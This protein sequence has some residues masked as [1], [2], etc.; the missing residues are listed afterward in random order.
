LGNREACIRVVQESDGSVK[1]FEIKSSDATANPYLALGVIIR[2]G[3]DGLERKL[4]LPDPVQ[5][6]PANLDDKERAKM[7]IDD[8]PSSPDEAIGR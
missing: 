7:G 8:L 1:H 2:A 6:D 3:M 4:K 5:M